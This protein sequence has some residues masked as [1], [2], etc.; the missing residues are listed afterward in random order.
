MK[1]RLKAGALNQRV[2]LQIIM[3][4]QDESDGEITETYVSIGD[5]WADVRMVSGREYVQGDARQSNVVATIRI[6]QRPGLEPSMRVIHKTRTFHVEA[7]L[8]DP[9]SGNEWATLACS[10]VRAG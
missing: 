1:S 2:T 5:V 8:D 7:V 6:R 9:E 10:E 3:S 4:E